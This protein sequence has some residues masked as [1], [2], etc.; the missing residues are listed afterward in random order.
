MQKE[1]QAINKAIEDLNSTDSKS[2]V[3]AII[4][5]P[6]ICNAIDTERVRKEFIPYLTSK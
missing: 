6:K 3:A 4:M 5:I 1:K 2:K